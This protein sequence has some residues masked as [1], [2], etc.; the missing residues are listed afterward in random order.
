MN[1][2]RLLNLAEFLEKLEDP[3]RFNFNYVV[4]AMDNNENRY[5][6]LTGHP[7]CNNILILNTITDEMQCK[8]VFCACGY[9]PIMDK[10]SG[11][12]WDLSVGNIIDNKGNQGYVAV[13]AEY[14]DIA[15]WDALNLF[16]A[17]QQGDIYNWGEGTPVCCELAT[18]K[19]VATAIRHYVDINK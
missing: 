2:V 6:I 15:R 8:S 10:D 1:T 11:I 18:A 19:E 9:I 12:S 13:A 17:N 5:K 3:T 14:F 4:A 7:D 16:T